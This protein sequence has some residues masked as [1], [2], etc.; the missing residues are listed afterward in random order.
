MPSQVWK[1]TNWISSFEPTDDELKAFPRGMSM[2]SGD[3][4]T[5]SPPE[6]G[7]NSNLNPD[8]GPIN[9]IKW[10][11]PRDGNNYEP[12]S[13]PADSD[14]SSA[15]IGDT[16]NKGEGVGFPDVD[17]DG[18]ASP[19]RADIH[20]PSCYNPDA[21]LMS[22]KDNMA[23][24]STKDGKLNC[25]EGYVHVPHLFLEVYWNTPVFADRWTPNTGK[26]PFVL[27]NG[28]ATGFSSHADFMAGWD[29]ELLQHIIDT[30]D[31]GTSGMDNCAGLFY[32][33]NDEDCTIPSEIDED[34]DG[35]LSKLPGNN[36][37]TGWR[38]GG[39][40]P[41]MPEPSSPA[42]SPTP[43][44]G[45]LDGLPDVAD[46]VATNVVE[47]PAA[48]TSTKSEEKAPVPKPTEVSEEASLPDQPE[49]PSQ[50]EQNE[51]PNN[52]VHT[53]WETITVTEEIQAQPTDSK[54]RRHLHGHGHAHGHVHRR[55]N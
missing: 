47:N 25:P 23:W 8:N 3:P 2:V 36:P 48:P 13:W 33:V 41:D 16:V 12:P 51:Q 11:C 52:R 38:F 27:S 42:S 26:Q 21:G 15:G 7:P 5:R 20:F 31:A 30:C 37:V 14:G 39:E 9:G 46:D 40:V 10:T 50:P 6:G 17:C 43:S 35:T 55:S 18:Y 4:M 29:E 53:I 49:K 34:V 24:P 22:Y 54:S 28:D 19:L 1:L 45:L 44:G 32:G